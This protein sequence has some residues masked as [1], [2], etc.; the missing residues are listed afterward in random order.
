MATNDLPEDTPTE[1]A[2]GDVPAR[3]PTSVWSI[4]RVL[5]V[6]GAVLQI[7]TL[8]LPWEHADVVDLHQGQD[9]LVPTFI[10]DPEVLNKVLNVVQPSYVVLAQIFWD[11]FWRSALLFI[12][13]LLV[14]AF[15]L[16]QRPVLR[17]TFAVLCGLWLL[18]TTVLA[19]SCAMTVHAL[20]VALTNHASNTGICSATTQGTGWE[21]IVQVDVLQGSCSGYPLSLAWGYWLYIAALVMCWL[22][23]GLTISTLVRSGG[24]GAG[25]AGS[26][27]PTRAKRTWL[28][29]ILITVGAM[30][31]VVSLVALPMLVTDCSRPFNPLTTP[32]CS[33]APVLYPL[34]VSV[35]SFL[36]NAISPFTTTADIYTPGNEILRIVWYFRNYD[37]LELAVAAVPLVLVAVWR[38]RVGRG[39]AAWVSVWA[40]AV[41][42]VTGFLLYVLNV[43]FLRPR[44][45][46]PMVSVIVGPG[47]VLMPLGA[48]LI[49]AGVVVY[50]LQLRGQDHPAAAAG[51]Y[52]G[53]T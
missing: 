7:V 28:A 45:G 12:G 53:K 44:F 3:P 13:L 14:L 42:V 23:L 20:D 18:Y 8:L 17:W 9:W 11:V 49:V 40:A 26:H 38:S 1:A 33:T 2:S 22:A 30:I 4:A 39:A 52:S 47:V 15:F 29:A 48:A 35:W 16:A 31:W 37:L 43:A 36:L 27:R 5:L 19:L 41:L 10:T 34:Q 51:E 50:W 6:V 21:Q 46:T 25:R 32:Q 24:G